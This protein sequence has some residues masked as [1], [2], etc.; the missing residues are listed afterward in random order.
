VL[1]DTKDIVFDSVRFH[2]EVQSSSRVPADVVDNVR[3][4]GSDAGVFRLQ[5][6]ETHSGVHLGA[7]S[8][9][10]WVMTTLLGLEGG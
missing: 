3:L 1:R 10:A 9:M 7:G 6:D 2:L 4:D 5:S 8:S